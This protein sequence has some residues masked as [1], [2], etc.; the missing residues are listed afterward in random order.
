MRACPQPCLRV[1][2]LSLSPQSPPGREQ[3][4]RGLGVQKG[5]GSP[6]TKMWKRKEEREALDRL[7][8]SE[9][10]PGSRQRAGGPRAIEGKR[11]H[12]L[13]WAKCWQKH[14]APRGCPRSAG[15]SRRAT[16]REKQSYFRASSTCR[17]PAV[18]RISHHV[19]S[20]VSKPQD[21]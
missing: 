14:E 1:P 13:I 11:R 5:G 7:C 9:P 18:H 20:H 6:V 12:L 19:T 8:S 17:A 3:A 4:G 2:T 15:R 10:S 21:P 16:W